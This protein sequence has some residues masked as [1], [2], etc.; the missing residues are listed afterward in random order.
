MIEA[1]LVIPTYRRPD[2]SAY[3]LECALA[4]QFLGTRFT[5]ETIVVDS[6]PDDYTWQAICRFEQ[7]LNLRYIKLDRQTPPGAARNMAVREAGHDI[8]VAVDSDVELMPQTVWNLISYLRDH[9]RVAWVTGRSMFACGSD[10]GLPDYPCLTADRIYRR[11]GTAFIE[12]I[13]GRYC[14]FYRSPFME[15]HGF[16]PLFEFC[17]ENTDLSHR[18]WRAGLPL[19]CDRETM[20][21]HNVSAPYGLT[22]AHP[23][24][25][26]SRYRTWILM[27]YKYG[28]CDPL[29]SSHFLQAV[30]QRL[31]SYGS[32]AFHSIRSVAESLDWFI[33][34]A[35]RIREA[36]ERVPNLFDFKLFDVFSDEML[37]NHCVD[38][39]AERIAPYHAPAFG[40]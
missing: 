10:K 8:I 39:A 29:N 35:E 15:L 11:H 40:T 6:S 17:G 9:P 25:I 26:V 4:S 14:A 32:I 28:M 20:A 37:L 23:D 34:N 19:A 22:R 7:P 18:F 13:R 12:T 21:Y 24:R 2:H 16:D 31:E 38:Q 36:K 30:Q 5:L 27:A 1:T 3:C 33:E